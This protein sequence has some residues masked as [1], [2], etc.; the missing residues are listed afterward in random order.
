ML[1]AS[2]QMVVL[3]LTHRAMIGKSL[4]ASFQGTGIKNQ[5]LSPDHS[6]QRST[7]LRRRARDGIFRRFSRYARDE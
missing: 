4:A 7:A 6:P 3:D 2:D 5:V 1:P